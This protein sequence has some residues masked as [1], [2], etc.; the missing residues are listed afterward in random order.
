MALYTHVR[1]RPEMKHIFVVRAVHPVTGKALDAGVLVSQVHH[2][3]AN[4]MG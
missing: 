3:I 1:N 2:L 4:R